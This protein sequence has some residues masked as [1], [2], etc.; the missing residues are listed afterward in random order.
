MD[1]ATFTNGDFD[2]VI[3]NNKRIEESSKVTREEVKAAEDAYDAATEQ[4]VN[5]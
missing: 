3:A 1:G 5:K 4:F 2:K